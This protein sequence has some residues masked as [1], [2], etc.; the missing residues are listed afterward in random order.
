MVEVEYTALNQSRYRNFNAT[1]LNE[2]AAIVN[3]VV[4]NNSAITSPNYLYAT[5]LA[6]GSSSTGTSTD[7]GDSSDSGNPAPSPNPRSSLAM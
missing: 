6:N 4:V 3:A 2:T 7:N 5:L 1:L